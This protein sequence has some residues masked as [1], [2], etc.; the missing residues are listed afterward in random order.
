MK[1]GR[2]NWIAAANAYY[3]IQMDWMIADW[4]DYTVDY[5]VI[6]YI[7]LEP[8]LHF[9]FLLILEMRNEMR[10]HHF[11]GKEK[12]NVMRHVY[13]QLPSLCVWSL[14]FNQQSNKLGENKVEA[15]RRNINKNETLRRHYTR[16]HGINFQSQSAF[17]SRMGIH[18]GN[19]PWQFFSSLFYS[20]VIVHKWIRKMI[21]LNN[22][23]A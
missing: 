10:Y 4:T 19:F 8:G 14:K 3:V 20:H 7:F 18:V 13:N 23:N 11:K 22:Q 21:S 12:W 5:K 15:N 6:T 2:L 16:T 9:I 17:L 1:D